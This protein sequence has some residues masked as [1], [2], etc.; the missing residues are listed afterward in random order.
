MVAQC[1]ILMAMSFSATCGE[2]ERLGSI[3][4]PGNTTDHSDLAG[5]IGNGT[6]HNLF[7]AISAM[8]H[9]EGNRFLALP[10]RGPLDGAS[11]FQCRFH[12]IELTHSSVKTPSVEFRLVKTLMLNTENGSPLVGALEAINRESPSKSL[13]FDPEGLR[14]SNEGT[15]F[16]SD[17]YGPS[18]YEFNLLGSRRRIVPTP[19]Q[20]AIA[21]PSADSKMEDQKN[22]MGRAANSGWEG[23]A[24]TPD[25][26]HLMLATQKT[27]L[28]DRP[29]LNGTKPPT[30]LVRLLEIDLRTQNT[31]QLVYRLDNEQSGISEILAINN[32]SYLVLERDGMSG[33]ASQNKKIYRITTEGASDVSSTQSLADEAVVSGLS[34]VKKTLLIDLLEPRWG[35]AGPEC[36]EKWEGLAFGPK[37]S[38]GRFL[39]WIAVD[40]DYVPSKPTWFHAFAIAPEELPG[41]TWK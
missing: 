20:F 18:L 27:L 41:C 29:R 36:P 21:N 15:V 38:D 3:S 24:I 16:I 39:L 40:N 25:G 28:Q 12:E 34:L 10:D 31:R 33:S 6:P 2:T 4:I 8:E 22:E 5:E 19:P 17:E 14:I 13:R 11:Q 7:G 26:S 32:Q 23:L 30:R 1:A 9:L 35:F 37:L